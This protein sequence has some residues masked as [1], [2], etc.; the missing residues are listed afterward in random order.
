MQKRGLTPKETALK[1]L[2]LQQDDGG[3]HGETPRAE[4]IH[5]DSSQLVPAPG[6][7]SVMIHKIHVE[8]VY[9]QALYGREFKVLDDEFHK[10]NFQQPQ[11]TR[12]TTVAH[13]PGTDQD[14]F[15]W[16]HSLLL[17]REQLLA[18]RPGNAE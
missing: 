16:L 1:I 11:G 8:P 10:L 15:G 4:A 14:S 13:F 18:S 7:F 17:P 2:E 12:P 3:D 9:A 6:A 5:G